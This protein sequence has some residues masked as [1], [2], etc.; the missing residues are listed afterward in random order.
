MEE[1]Q[2]VENR[3]DGQIHGASGSRLWE[4]CIEL[5]RIA[6]ETGIKSLR[7]VIENSGRIVNSEEDKLRGAKKK[8]RNLSEAPRNLERRRPVRGTVPI[9]W[10]SK[11]PRMAS[12]LSMT[13]AVQILLLLGSK[14]FNNPRD[15]SKEESGNI[16]E[17]DLKSRRVSRSSILLGSCRISLLQPRG[18]GLQEADALVVGLV[19]RRFASGRFLVSPMSAQFQRSRISTILASFRRPIAQQPDGQPHFPDINFSP[20]PFVLEGNIK[21]LSA[22][23]YSDITASE[24]LWDDYDGDRR[25]GKDTHFGLPGGY[26]RI[27]GLSLKNA[28]T[29]RDTRIVSLSALEFPVPG[30]LSS[31]ASHSVRITEASSVTQD[32]LGV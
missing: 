23:L 14:C 19:Q 3:G 18:G 1:Q 7:V 12:G 24:I 21:S 10:V 20:D 15:L 27:S 11:A 9:S 22:P 31:L 5:L 6:I 32:G 25:L 13:I 8:N 16:S 28:C 29:V 30:E 17:A 2:E 26:P 4:L